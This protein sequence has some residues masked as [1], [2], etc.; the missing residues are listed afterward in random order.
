V[1]IRRFFRTTVLSTSVAT[2]VAVSGTSAQMGPSYP[3]LPDVGFEAPENDALPT[4]IHFG[5]ESG[6]TGGPYR[7]TEFFQGVTST[8]GGGAWSQRDNTWGICFNLDKCSGLR[9]LPDLYDFSYTLE[10]AYQASPSSATLIEQNFNMRYADGTF[11][12]PWAMHIWTEQKSAVLNFS[13]TPGGV[14]F[15]VNQNGNTVIGRPFRQPIKQLEVVG[16]EL[17]TGDLDVDG[18]LRVDGYPVLVNVGS[19]TSGPARWAVSNG[20]SLD[21][22]AEVCAESRLEC[23]SAMLPSSQILECSSSI[24]QGLVFFALCR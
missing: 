9:I 4:G 16:D 1:R 18:E 21:S 15:Q 7:F 12:R 17:V 10:S 22:A 8:E 24:E 3:L 5:V 2:V 19:Q 20:E 6:P 11:H 14:S 23:G 13:S